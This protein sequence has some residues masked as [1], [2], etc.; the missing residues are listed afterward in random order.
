MSEP[1]KACNYCAE[2]GQT[3]KEHPHSKSFATYFLHEVVYDHSLWQWLGFYVTCWYAS[4]YL[5]QHHYYQTICK[6]YIIGASNS[7]NV[8]VLQ[9]HTKNY[10]LTAN[11]FVTLIHSISCVIGNIIGYRYQMR[12][13]KQS[14]SNNN[15][16]N[17]NNNSNSNNNQNKLFLLYDEK[18]KFIGNNT[19]A[20]FI[21]DCIF[22]I[23]PF[24]IIKQIKQMKK[25]QQIKYD[26]ILSLIH[27]FLALF[28][29][30]AYFLRKKIIPMTIIQSIGIY[31]EFSTVFLS[32]SKIVNDVKSF[33][34]QMEKNINNNI[35]N[36]QLMIILSK[37]NYW[38]KMFL[39]IF[40]ISFLYSRFYVMP[41]IAYLIT[42]Y[43]H[44]SNHDECDQL[45]VLIKKI[46]SGCLAVGIILGYV[47]GINVIRRIIKSLYN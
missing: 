47:W 26:G 18:T 6:R 25:N 22:F 1:A 21:M 8:N 44:Q 24:R 4:C 46:M 45:Q 28:I 32:L 20:F 3:Q 36:V 39:I 40:G 12:K 13:M 31:S 43:L 16:N 35:T 34:C 7:V 10:P 19:C 14:H 23:I 9:Q 17:N 30:F 11:R 38:N 29:W 41:K 2:F 33:L 37:L 42:D 27:H 5:S 15:N